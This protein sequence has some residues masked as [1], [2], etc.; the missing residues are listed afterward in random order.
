MAL[1]ISEEETNLDEWIEKAKVDT[2]LYSSIFRD[3]VDL[4]RIRVVQ[5]KLDAICLV[6]KELAN[7]KATNRDGDKK[8][9]LK[10]KKDKHRR[11]RSS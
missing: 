2:D 9:K 5:A 10:K 6:K 1:L 11:P 7:T 4:T 3:A 8:L